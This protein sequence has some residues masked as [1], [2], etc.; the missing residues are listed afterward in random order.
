MVQ[1][2]A[3]V[4]GSIC[5]AYLVQEVSSYVSMYFDSTVET[6]ATQPRRHDDFVDHGIGIDNQLS[7]F[8]HPCRPTAIKKS[9][10]YLDDEN[11]E[12]AHMYIL[13]NT[14]EVKPILE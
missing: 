12:C 14:P 13:A 2:K 1:Q 7:I 5:E 10:P 8:C 4:E 3:H 6:N 9:G 11:W